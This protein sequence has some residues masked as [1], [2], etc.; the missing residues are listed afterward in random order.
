[1]ERL[2]HG[3][4]PTGATVIT[5][6]DGFYS[7]LRCAAP[8]LESYSFPAT[9]YVTT[10]YSVK[11]TP[12]FRLA[13]QYMFWK[14]PLSQLDMT[15]FV[16]PVTGLVSW[17]TEAEKDRVMWDIIRF[18]ETQLTETQRS[19]LAAGIGWK[20]HVSYESIARQRTLSLLTTS[21]TQELARNGF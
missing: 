5:I 19:E 2:R 6:D 10:Y 18:G 12:V 15:E 9:I 17:H 20:L 11:E 14:T 21:E 16:T 8:L 3:N 13:I 7:V 1:L 4:L